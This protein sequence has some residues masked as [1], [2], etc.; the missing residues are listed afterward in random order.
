LRNHRLIKLKETFWENNG[1]IPKEKLDVLGKE[2]QEFIITYKQL[3]IEYQQSF[4]IDIDLT[5]VQLTR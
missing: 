1:I 4:K 5:K 2:E 3:N